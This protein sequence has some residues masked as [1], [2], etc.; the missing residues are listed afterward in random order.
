[1][2]PTLIIAA[3]TCLVIWL[4]G[5]I[6]LWQK[7]SASRPFVSVGAVDRLCALVWPLLYVAALFAILLAILR[8]R[9]HRG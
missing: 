5:L 2:N 1:M 3:L 9:I 4:I 7:Q 8:H 6:H